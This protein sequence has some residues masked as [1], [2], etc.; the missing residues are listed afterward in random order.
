MNI[1]NKVRG[2]PNKQNEFGQSELIFVVYLTFNI[3]FPARTVRLLTLLSKFCRA[4]GN[5]RRPRMY[6]RGNRQKRFR[7]PI[8]SISG[9]GVFRL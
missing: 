5:T 3:V 8:I 1:I 6:Y 4:R 7:L 2:A 9:R